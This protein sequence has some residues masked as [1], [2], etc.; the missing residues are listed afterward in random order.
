MNWCELGIPNPRCHMVSWL[1]CEHVKSNASYLSCKSS[2]KWP[3]QK[4]EMCYHSYDHKAWYYNLFSYLFVS[5]FFFVFCFPF[6]FPNCNFFMWGIHSSPKHLHWKVQWY[7]Q[8]FSYGWEGKVWEGASVWFS[9][10]F[11]LI[12]AFPIWG[13]RARLSI[14]KSR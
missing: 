7:N 6:S 4:C 13:R 1:R 5:C 8:T 3:N 11:F 10:N 2:L 14:I 9:I 12:F